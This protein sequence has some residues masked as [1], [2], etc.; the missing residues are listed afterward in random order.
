MT[1]RAHIEDTIRSL[2]AA[3]IRGDLE[4]V[5]K[6]VADDA[7][8]MLNGRGTGNPAMA[9]AQ[10]SKPAIRPVIQQFIDNF[11]FDDWKELALLVD[12][13]RALLHWTARVTCVPTNKTDQFEVFDLLT[14]RDGKIVDYRQCTDT[15]L[16]AS[17]AM[18]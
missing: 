7:V 5:M 6:S 18:P 10:R 15:A 16:V 17:I 2:Y 1:S 4:G 13:D 3:R 11:R 9:S 8:F 14:F 12:G